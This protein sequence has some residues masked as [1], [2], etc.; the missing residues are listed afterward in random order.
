[1]STSAAP[2]APHPRG[3]DYN[4]PTCGE[5]RCNGHGTCVIPPGGGTGPVCDCALGYRGESC[6]DTVNGALSVPLTASVIAVILGVLIL[7]FIIA[8]IRQ[9]QKRNRRQQLAARHGYNIAV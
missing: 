1:M 6:E 5:T 8:K 4:L 7:A 9:R 2:I 3:I